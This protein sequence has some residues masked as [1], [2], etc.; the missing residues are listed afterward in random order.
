[1]ESAEEKTPHILAQYLLDL[2][3]AW[4][5]YYNA[6]EGGRPA[7]PVLTAE[8]GLRE[9]RLALVE[10]LQKTLSTGLGLLGIPAPEVM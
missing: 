5:A 2:A 8:E 3:A 6:K 9:L 10:S 7:T 4:N 1:L